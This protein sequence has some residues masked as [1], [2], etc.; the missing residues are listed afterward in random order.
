MENYAIFGFVLGGAAIFG[1]AV[2]F[3]HREVKSRQRRARRRGRDGR[4]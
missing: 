2:G 4:R 1:F 3:W